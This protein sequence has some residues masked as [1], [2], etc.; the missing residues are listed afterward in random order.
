MLQEFIDIAAEM[1]ERKQEQVRALALVEALESG[2]LGQD[3][4]RPDCPC[5]WLLAG[6]KDKPA[7]ALGLS[8]SETQPAA[9]PRFPGPVPW[10]GSPFMPAGQAEGPGHPSWDRPATVGRDI[11]QLLLS[12]V[13]GRLEAAQLC[14]ARA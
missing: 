3:G 12:L 14:L 1:S 11:P 6:R 9:K 4:P 13:L 8:Q 7:L 5:S 2:R 10:P